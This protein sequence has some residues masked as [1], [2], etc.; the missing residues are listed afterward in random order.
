MKRIKDGLLSLM[1]WFGFVV[2]PVALG[3][4]FFTFLAI[5]ETRDAFIV[6]A[7]RIRD[8]VKARLSEPEHAF[9]DL[10]K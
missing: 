10:R 6:A 3:L 4:L 9:L 2:V 7:L 8:A 1:F 5:T